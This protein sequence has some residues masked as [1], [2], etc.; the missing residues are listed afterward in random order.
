M[1]YHPY[2]RPL[3]M[4][5]VRCVAVDKKLEQIDPN[6]FNFLMSF[7]KD[8]DLRVVDCRQLIE[9]VYPNKFL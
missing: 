1:S 6:V 3:T 2:V 9:E 4:E 5:N 7:A 8:N